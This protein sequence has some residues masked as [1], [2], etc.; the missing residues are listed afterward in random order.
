MRPLPKPGQRSTQ[1]MLHCES[2][3]AVQGREAQCQGGQ[4]WLCRLITPPHGHAAWWKGQQHM[5]NSATSGK[6]MNSAQ[7][8]A[9]FLNLA[10]IF[11]NQHPRCM[12]IGFEDK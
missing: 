12:L 3:A 5:L 9:E 2:G 6:T 7:P 4:G 8:G 1:P 11:S 10:N